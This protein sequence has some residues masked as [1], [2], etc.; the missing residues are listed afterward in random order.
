MW[1]NVKKSSVI[2]GYSYSLILTNNRIRL[3]VYRS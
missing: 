1:H 3:T 2:V